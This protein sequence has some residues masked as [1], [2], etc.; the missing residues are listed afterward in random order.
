M[1]ASDI[2][3][4]FLL[5]PLDQDQELYQKISEA[6]TEQ[7]VPIITLQRNILCD[8]F[9]VPKD[10]NSNAIYHLLHE[11]LYKLSLEQNIPLKSVIRS[12]FRDYFDMP[13]RAKLQ[14]EK[15]GWPLQQR[16]KRFQVLSFLVTVDAATMQEIADQLNT[17]KKRIEGVV[18]FNSHYFVSSSI[19]HD[20]WRQWRATEKGR[21][22]YFAIVNRAQTVM[23]LKLQKARAE[24]EKMKAKA[25]EA[26]IE[27]VEKLEKYV[28]RRGE[29]RE[30]KEAKLAEKRQK[31]LQVHRKTTVANI[32]R[33]ARKA[34]AKVEIE[35]RGIQKYFS[36]DPSN[37]IDAEIVRRLEALGRGVGSQEERYCK[38][39]LMK[40]LAL[41]AGPNYS[42]GE[43]LIEKK[44]SERCQKKGKTR[45]DYV[46]ELFCIHFNIKIRE[47]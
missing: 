40:R 17:T 19:P 37:P 16:E 47:V 12:H 28:Q 14:Y 25:E 15:K 30:K 24:I 7:N 42:G 32:E 29:I 5:A 11:I 33:D 46:R 41:H 1:R 38:T 22:D 43:E 6:A 3:A 23:E 2:V 39:I 45:N 10:Y 4:S 35:K 36:P 27:K 8:I 9:N 34:E 21:Q 20:K 13:A 44:L 26:E 31:G 18:R